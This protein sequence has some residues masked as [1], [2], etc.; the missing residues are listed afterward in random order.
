M[1][2]IAYIVTFLVG[3]LAFGQNEQLFE[4]GN[5]LYNEGSYTAALEKYQKIIESGEHSAELYFNIG[6]AHYKLNNIA[7]SIY[8]FADPR[9]EQ[10]R[11]F[12][13]ESNVRGIDTEI[14]SE[15]KAVVTILYCS[16]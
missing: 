5:T 2:V 12:G 4:E 9:V 14:S 15:V 16:A 6:N 10:R 3:V 11:L 8:Y 13:E 7:P 1:K